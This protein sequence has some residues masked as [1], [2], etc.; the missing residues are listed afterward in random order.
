M[1][2]LA[3]NA[4]VNVH[5]PGALLQ[6]RRLERTAFESVNFAEALKGPKKC[7][8]HATGTNGPGLGAKFMISLRK[9]AA[10]SFY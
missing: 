5:S 9:E 2:H 1:R 3:R 6:G 7:G 10:I 4:V 8:I